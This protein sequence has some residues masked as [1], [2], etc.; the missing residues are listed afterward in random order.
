MPNIALSSEPVF[1]S[2]RLR[3]EHS[4]SGS[5]PRLDQIQIHARMVL[6]ILRFSALYRT[7]C[8]ELNALPRASITVH[9]FRMFF[10]A[11]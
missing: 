7:D 1:E 4:A 5:V 3:T 6:A 2:D 9:T 10:A 11:F 8:A